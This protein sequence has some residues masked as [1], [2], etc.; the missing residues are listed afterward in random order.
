MNGP[1]HKVNTDVN[2]EAAAVLDPVKLVGL[3]RLWSECL[4]EK[5]VV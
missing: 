5:R 4:V 3:G 1:R 2:R